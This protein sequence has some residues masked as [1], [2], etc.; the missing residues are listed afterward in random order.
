MKIKPS[1]RFLRF[2]RLFNDAVRSKNR[3]K[4]IEVLLRVPVSGD[5]ARRTAEQ[6]L[7]E[8]SAT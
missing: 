5:K 2:D 1:P 4:I 3:S 7:G 6:V 8:H